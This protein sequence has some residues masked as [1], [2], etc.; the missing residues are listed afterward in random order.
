MNKF[1]K[2]EASTTGTVLV[3]LDNIG[4]VAKASDT[5][6]TITYASATASADVLTIT[7]TS[8]ATTSTVNAIIDAIIKAGR[9]D[10]APDQ[11]V[12]PV[13]PSGITI[14]AVAIA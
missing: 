3:G 6:V 13:L 9:P 1:L 14:S 7:H 4:L 11:F 2:I 8:N 5:T 12:V 10:N